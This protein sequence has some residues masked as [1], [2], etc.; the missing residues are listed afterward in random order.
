M[1]VKW[2]KLSE[3]TLKGVDQYM[4][5]RCGEF[6]LFENMYSTVPMSKAGKQMLQGYIHCA[7]CR[8]H[9]DPQTAWKQ[10]HDR[11]YES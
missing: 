6:D 4:C 10:A 11:E 7:T 3:I 2:A 8:R 5:C 1:S 9:V